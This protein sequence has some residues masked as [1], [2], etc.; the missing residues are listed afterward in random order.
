MH[1]RMER[2]LS[3]PDIKEYATFKNQGYLN[4]SYPK[5]LRGAVELAVGS[6]QAFCELPQEAKQK[7]LYT[8]PS[9]GIGYELKEGT[10]KHADKKENFDITIAGRKWLK[11]NRSEIAP[12]AL[13]F[14]ENASNLVRVAKPMILKFA[15][16]AERAFGLKGFLKE[17]RASDAAF[18]FRFIHYFGNRREGDEIAAPHVDQSGFTL[19][20]YESAPGLER[21]TYDKKWVD[22]PVSDGETAIIPAM[23]M[24]LCSKGVLR[25]TCHRVVATKDTAK[26]GRF[27]SVCFIQLKNTPKYDKARGGRLQ[28][29]KPGFNYAMPIEEFAKLFK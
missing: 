29:K 18:F 19:H 27:S 21:L 13:K 9:D 20:L 7:F 24:Q 2:K 3:V 6:W 26:T 12:D 22:M 17:V 5:E 4:L 28:E 14:V 10:G 15:L 1:I 11:E 16:D 25:A 23:Q 8:S